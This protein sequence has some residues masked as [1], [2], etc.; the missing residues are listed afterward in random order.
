M[1]DH[2][3]AFQQAF[4]NDPEMRALADL[5]I[6]GWPKEIKEGPLSPPP[7]LATQRDPHHQGWSSLAR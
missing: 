4:I 7:I 3:E 1:P 2:K 6:T 5:I